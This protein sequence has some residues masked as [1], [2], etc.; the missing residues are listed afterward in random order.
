[1]PATAAVG[2]AVGISYVAETSFGVPPSSPTMKALRI[3]SG[4]KFE[5]KRDTFQSKE[6]T[7][8]RQVMGMTYGTRSGS[9]ELPFELSY[10]SFDDFLEAVFGGTWN[11]NV[12]K[13]GNTKRSF[14]MEQQFPDINLNE[15]NTGVVMTGFNLSVKPNAAV[16]GGFSALFKDQA[17]VQYADDGVTTMA[18]AATTITRS[19]GSFITDGFAVGDTVTV[20]GAS[21]AGNNKNIVITTLTATVMT[22]SAAG[23]SVDT[24]KT[25]VTLC[26]TLGTPTAANTNPVFD[27]FTGTMLVDGTAAAIVTGIDVKVDQ[28]GQANNTLFSDTAA[29]VTL[30]TVNVTGSVVVR[31]INNA[32]KKK[33]LSGASVDLSFTLGNGSAKSYK[34]DMSNCKFTSAATDT[35]ENELTQTLNYQAIYDSTDA[36]TMMI[37]RYP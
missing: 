29:S 15:Q 10:G 1:M 37:T 18:F 35:G 9:A 14:T 26:K 16:E 8:A 20:T 33:Y 30:S 27:S 6:L 5:L 11:T 31:F 34:F 19:A 7:T 3:K 23:F 13:I 25:G 17:S 36:T 28:S 2:T 12:L 22:A 24:A 21:V 32:L 4:T